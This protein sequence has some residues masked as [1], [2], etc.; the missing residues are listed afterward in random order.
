MSWSFHSD[1][2]I[3]TQLVDAIKLKIISGAFPAGSRMSSVRDLALEAGVNPNTMQ[4]ALQQLEREGLVFTQRS[5]GRFVTED[6]TSIDR[7]RA[8][9]AA[10]HV[11]RYRESMRR[12][13]FSGEEMK[14]LLSG[15]GEERDN[16][17]LS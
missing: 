16:G 5:S 9:L 14:A 1:L 2:P 8:A 12:L 10:E 15:G 13:G 3:Y 17:S 6:I 4:R 7:A 11:R